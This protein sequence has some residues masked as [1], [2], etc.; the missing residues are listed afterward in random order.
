VVLESDVAVAGYSWLQAQRQMASFAHVC[1]YDRAGYGWSDPGP[2]PN[3]SD[4]VA[5]DLHNLLTAAHI[6]PPY[7]LV[8]HGIGGFHARVYNGLYPDDV[9]GMVL[10]DPLNEDTTIHVHNH[11]ENLRPTVVELMKVL[12]VIGVLR[13]IAPGP[14]TTPPGWTQNEWNTAVATAWQPGSAVAHIHEGPLWISGE[15][16][17]SSGHLGNI[18]LMVLSGEK[19]AE[20]FRGQNVELEIDRHEALAR[21]SLRGRHRIVAGSGYWNP[22]KS[23]QGVVDAVRDVLAQD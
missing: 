22:Y 3:H 18:P 6:R 11:D 13:F 7:M 21:Q 2:F 8:G 9:A 23:P 4:S 5:R 14:G 16:A 19:H 10:V 20:L 15:L 12:G 1:W 17:R